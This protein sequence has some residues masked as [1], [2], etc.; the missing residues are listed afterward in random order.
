MESLSQNAQSILL[1]HLI[2]DLSDMVLQYCWKVESIYRSPT[3]LYGLCGN[4]EYYTKRNIDIF[5]KV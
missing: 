5:L 4:Y 1:R 2:P 3:V